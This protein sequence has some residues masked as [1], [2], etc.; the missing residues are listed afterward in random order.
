MKFLTRVNSTTAYGAVILI[1]FMVGGI[2]LS[3]GIQKFL[4]ADANGVGRFAKI[5]IPS[6]EIMAPFVGGVEIFCGTLVVLGLFTRLVS[7]PLLATIIAA[8][9]STKMPILLGHGFLCFNL[10][11]LAH[12]GFWSMVHEARADVSMLLGLVFLICVGAGRWSVDAQIWSR[13][14]PMEPTEWSSI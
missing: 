7:L 8:I 11:Q 6:P 5:G 10:P 4:F 3:E 9:L 13:A 1:R 12:Y 14:K 2:F